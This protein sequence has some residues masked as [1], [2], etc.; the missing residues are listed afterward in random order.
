LS[1]FA[2]EVANEIECR[3][4]MA[5]LLELEMQDWYRRATR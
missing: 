1:A 4:T 5:A 3:D 2:E